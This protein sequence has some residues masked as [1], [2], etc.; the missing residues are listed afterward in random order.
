MRFANRAK[1]N[2]A[3]IASSFTYFRDLEVSQLLTDVILKLHPV[4]KNSILTKDL[5]TILKM[6]KNPRS[7][8][9]TLLQVRAKRNSCAPSLLL[10]DIK[11]TQ[12]LFDIFQVERL[13]WFLFR[14]YIWKRKKYLSDQTAR[15]FQHEDAVKRFWCISVLVRQPGVGFERKRRQTL[16]LTTIN[17]YALLTSCACK[18][19]GRGEGDR[20]HP[21]TY[22]SIFFHPNFVQFG[23]QHSRYK[24]ISHPL[25]CLRS[26]VKYT[27]SVVKYSSSLVQQRGRSWLP[28]I[29][30]IP[31]PKLTGWIP[32]CLWVRLLE[33]STL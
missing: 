15:E 26:V 27:S 3:F 32:P 4:P 17:R 2:G 13:L 24:A 7:G 5:E 23:K 1:Q 33:Y 19:V 6:W 12:T 14:R 9:E 16:L 28:H 31:P 18:L 10:I 29:T 20:S 22:E 21:K 8:F 30:E 25:F 11:A